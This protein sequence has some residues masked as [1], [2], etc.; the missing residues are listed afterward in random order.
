MP[1]FRPSEKQLRLVAPALANSGLS[2]HQMSGVTDAR[3]AGLVAR[4]GS[5]LVVSE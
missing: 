4:L 2:W 5:G 1:P 3:S